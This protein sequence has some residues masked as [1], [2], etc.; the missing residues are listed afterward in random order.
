MI[1]YYASK[2]SGNMAKTP[3]GFLLCQN[4][5]IA[6]VGKQKYTGYEISS[7]V[8]IDPQE[9]VDVYRAAEDVFSS[10]AMAS[11]EGKP[12]TNEHPPDMLTPHDAARYLKGVCQNIRRDK[13]YLVAD[14]LIYDAELIRQIEN[15]KRGVSCGYRSLF[16]MRE[17]KIYQTNIEG[18]HIAIVEKGRAGEKVAIK[19]NAL[20][21]SSMSMNKNRIST[22]G[23]GVAVALANILPY[24]N[25]DAKP[26]EVAEVVEELV[27]AVKNESDVDTA[28]SPTSAKNLDDSGDYYELIYHVLE[29]LD[30]RAC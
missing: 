11:F 3:E 7:H 6:K 5:P 25:R 15:G 21:G 27:E 29:S 26:D 30:A 19:D 14:F 8:N 1:T 13:Q 17:N 10:P 23:K 12:I 22:R 24:F 28:D 9:I 16:E 20:G 2:I 18:N 4:V